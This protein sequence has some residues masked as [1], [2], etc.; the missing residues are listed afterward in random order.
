LF[1]LLQAL[2]L[3]LVRALLLRQRAAQTEEAQHKL[4]AQVYQPL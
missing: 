1:I 2:L 3:A 4:L